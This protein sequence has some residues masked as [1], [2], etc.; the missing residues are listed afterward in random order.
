MIELA[1]D[2]DDDLGKN[3]RE[4]LAL[5]C[6]ESLCGP[7]NEVNNAH[8]KVG[9]DFSES[10]E[11]VL[12]HIMHEVNF[13]FFP[14][15]NSCFV[16][17]IACVFNHLLPN[18]RS[19]NF[20]FDVEH[21]HLFCQN[22]LSDLEMLKLELVKRDLRPFIIHKRACMPKLA[23]QQVK[24]GFFPPASSLMNFPLFHLL[25]FTIHYLVLCASLSTAERFNSQRYS[26]IC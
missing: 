7:T 1:P 23:V 16:C 9:F 5:R 26:S 17:N 20:H 11:D 8:S 13:F 18:F 24:G 4:M 10:C 15:F 14:N 3:M 22:S 21:K 25:S 6:L 19:L 2:L 12:Q